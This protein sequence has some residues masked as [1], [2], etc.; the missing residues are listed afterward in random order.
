MLDNFGTKCIKT[1]L[2][3]LTTVES[4]AYQ[5]EVLVVDDDQS[6]RSIMTALLKRVGLK[7]NLAIDGLDAVEWLMRP[8]NHADLVILDLAMPRMSGAEA[9]EHIRS[10]RP[11]LGIV[12]CSGSK[13]DLATTQEQGGEAVL[14]AFSKPFDIDEF[15][16]G[17]LVALSRMRGRP[18][19]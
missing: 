15:C 1:I 19:P 3:M 10:M 7:V 2:T 6:I 8:E 13:T 4:P 9:L 18:F 11:E 5:S 12:L 17:I 14:S 16:R